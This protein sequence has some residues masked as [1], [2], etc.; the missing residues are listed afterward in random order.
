M[1]PLSVSSKHRGVIS[2]TPSTPTVKNLS[3]SEALCSLWPCRKERGQPGFSGRQSV[4]D[5][6][7]VK[8]SDSCVMGYLRV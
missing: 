4:S 5:S 6:G 2:K 7:L 8:C 3:G 1:R